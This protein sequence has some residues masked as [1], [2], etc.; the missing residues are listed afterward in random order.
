MQTCK[1]FGRVATTAEEHRK[2]RQAKSKKTEGVRNDE[3][4]TNNPVIA[5]VV[6]LD[7]CS[8]FNVYECI[9]THIIAV[10]LH[11]CGDEEITP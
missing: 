11:L 3:R 5:W 2:M 9:Y 4:A 6:R 10:L 7:Y 1:S 8:E